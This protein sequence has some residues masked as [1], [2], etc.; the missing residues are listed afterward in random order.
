[1]I[2]HGLRLH[3]WFLEHPSDHLYSHITEPLLCTLPSTLSPF[4]AANKEYREQSR[5]QP[6]CSYGYCHIDH[7]YLQNPLQLSPT[8]TASE[9]DLDPD[10]NKE[11]KPEDPPVEEAPFQIPVPLPKFFY[12]SMVTIMNASYCI[13]NQ[14]DMLFK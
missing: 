9:T 4:P 11:N 14:V 12:H 5:Y 3:V 8:D 2:N 10:I 6:D 13:F 7:A 1:M